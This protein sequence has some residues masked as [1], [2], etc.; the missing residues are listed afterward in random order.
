VNGDR[1]GWGILGAGKLAGRF[2]HG[3]CE[4]L[5]SDPA[6]DLVEVATPQSLHAEVAPRHRPRTMGAPTRSGAT[7]PRRLAPEQHRNSVRLGRLEQPT[8]AR[9]GA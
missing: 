6:V 5:V 9:G 8:P 3:S 4:S 1:L 2:A 7:S